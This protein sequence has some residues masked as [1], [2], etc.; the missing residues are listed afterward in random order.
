MNFLYGAYGFDL[1]SIFLLILSFI[2]S[3]MRHTRILAMILNLIVLYRAFSKNIYKRS[4][5]LN[6]FTNLLNKVLSKFG[7][8]LPDNFPRATLDGIPRLF[9]ELKYSFN[10]KIKFKIVVCPRCNQKLRLPRGK[11]NIIVTCRKC[12]YEFKAR[13]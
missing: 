3:F 11:K 4:S 6:K 7:R 5:E 2:F 1:L 13:T 9:N 12:S 8:K 10:Q